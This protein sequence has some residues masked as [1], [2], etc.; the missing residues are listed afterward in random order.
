VAR[1]ADLQDDHVGLDGEPAVLTWQDGRLSGTPA[2]VRAVEQLAASAEG[3]PVR[4]FGGTSTW[5][6]HLAHAV[7]AYTLMR[8]LFAQ[9]PDCT[10]DVPALPHDVV[11]DS[12]PGQLGRGPRGR[13]D[14]PRA[15]TRAKRRATAPRR[16]TPRT[17][18]GD[19]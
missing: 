14:R 10:G 12:P 6:D 8:A 17:N 2:L 4:W 1:D 3:Q 13:Y 19:Q 11:I 5:H 18:P 7:S 16:P 15:V 9:H